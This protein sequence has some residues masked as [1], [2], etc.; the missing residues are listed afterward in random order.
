MRFIDPDGMQQGYPQATREPTT[1]VTIF[2]SQTADATEDPE[3]T[4]NV[5][6]QTAVINEDGSSVITDI[7]AMIDNEGKITGY[8]TTTV[9]TTLESGVDIMGNPTITH[10]TEVNTRKLS[11]QESSFV[12]DYADNI[13]AEVKKNSN[14]V[15]DAIVTKTS[16][17]TARDCQAGGNLSLWVAGMLASYA[18]YAIAIPSPD[19]VTKGTAAAAAEGALFFGAVGG[20]MNYA[21]GITKDYKLGSPNG[22]LLLN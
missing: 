5:T 17:N 1:Q 7:T 13:A 11:E 21:G 20:V 10:N 3:A 8:S 6:Y 9:T 19:P 14:Y 18:V 2:A 15:R 16:E 22:I 4:R 12:K